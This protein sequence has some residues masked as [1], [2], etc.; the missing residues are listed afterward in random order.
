MRV[1]RPERS[2]FFVWEVCRTALRERSLL[3]E[4]ALWQAVG[5]PPLLP[6]ELPDGAGRFWLK[7][8]WL[9]P[10]G[11]VK[12]RAARAILRDAIRRGLVP[13]RRLLDASR[14]NTLIAFVVVGGAAGCDVTIC[15][16]AK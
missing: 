15:L 4:P 3:R 16:S 6:V 13:G 14:G 8:E 2:G 5:N 9:N 7:A 11:S 12:D 1:T 10:G